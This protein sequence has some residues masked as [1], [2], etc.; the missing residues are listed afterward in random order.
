MFRVSLQ[1]E[2]CCRDPA[3]GSGLSSFRCLVYVFINEKRKPKPSYYWI[4]VSDMSSCQFSVRQLPVASYEFPVKETL[5]STIALNS[6][7][8]TGY[9]LLLLWSLVTGN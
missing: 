4:Q 3:N 8:V 2:M 6:V 5:D 7:L 9:W 1:A